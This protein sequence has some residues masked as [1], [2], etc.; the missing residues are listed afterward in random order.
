MMHDK[1]NPS[2]S[3]LQFNGGNS[4]LHLKLKWDNLGLW[5]MSKLWMNQRAIFL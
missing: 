4:D 2:F 5:N 3:Q 1:K